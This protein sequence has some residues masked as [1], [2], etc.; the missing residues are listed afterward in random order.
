MEYTNSPLVTYTKLS[1]NN[2]G[3]RTHAIDRITPHHTV[4]LM[5]VEALG[6]EFA[7]TSRQASSN[8]GIGADAR[9]GLYVP[10]SSRAWT[11]GSK[12]ND[13]RAVT[14][15]C[16]DEASY[17]YRLSDAV[18]ARLIELCVDICRRNGKKKLLWFGDKEK[19]LSYDLQPDEMLLTVHR[20]FQATQCPGQ[21]LMEHMA[22]LAEKVTKEL[23]SGVAPTQPT[24]PV[25]TPVVSSNQ[26]FALGG[27]PVLRFGDK[28]GYVYTMQH[29]LI[30]HKCPVGADGA[31]GKFGPSTL[32]GLKNYQTMNKLT[33]DGVCGPKTWASLMKFE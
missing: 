28:Y 22:D 5:S 6:A 1:P 26:Y 32:I 33:V 15:E 20:W 7:Q 27:I 29:L 23:N 3:T 18:Y 19:S 12:E 16:A 4:G 10:E 24:T 2:S 25:N 14:I 31:D 9:V 8:Y 21:W 17:P 11:S 13:Q 30:A